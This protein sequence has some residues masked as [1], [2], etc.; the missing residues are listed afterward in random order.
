MVWPAGAAAGACGAAGAPPASCSADVQFGFRHAPPASWQAWCIV[1][2]HCGQ[3]Q[4]SWPSSTSA[5]QPGQIRPASALFAFIRSGKLCVAAGR[6]PTG[7][8]CGEVPNPAAPQC[9]HVL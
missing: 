8:G 6:D 1:F 3:F 9:G 7:M 5:W 2:W 4:T